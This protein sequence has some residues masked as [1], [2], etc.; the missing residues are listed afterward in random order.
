MVRENVI[1]SKLHSLN[2]SCVR[3]TLQYPESGAVVSIELVKF[4]LLINFEF[5][6][7]HELN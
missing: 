4:R 5:E 6:I 7:F 2:V 3:C 1:S